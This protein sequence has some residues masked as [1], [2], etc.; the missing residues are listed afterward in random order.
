MH[1]NNVTWLKSLKARF[2]ND[3]I[4]N[5]VLEVG[6]NEDGWTR[7]FF[8]KCQYIGIDL[9]RGNNVDIVG[10]VNTYNFGNMK[11]DTIVLLSV[12]EHDPTWQNT[13]KTCINLLTEDGA[14]I[15]GFG[16][17]GNNYHPPDPWCTVPHK[18]FLTELCTYDDVAIVEAFFEEQMY[19]N[20]M[21]RCFNTFIR[22]GIPQPDEWSETGKWNSTGTYP[23]QLRGNRGSWNSDTLSHD[24]D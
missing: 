18:E 20:P 22:K 1:D 19:G 6:S 24:P 5:R 10:D 14:M 21:V 11:F 3:F 23:W 4:D 8:E 15:I 17:E 7:S 16:P 9:L 12:F 2:P 13:L